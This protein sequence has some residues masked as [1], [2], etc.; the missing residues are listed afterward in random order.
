GDKYYF[1][2]INF[3]GNNAYEDEYLHQILRIKKGDA[4][5]GTLLEKRIADN[6]KPDA[7]DI[8]NLYQN[9][10][11]LFSQINPVETKVY[12][13]TIDFEIRIMEGK[14]AHFD[15]VYVTGNDKTNDHVIYRNLR[16]RPGEHTVKRMWSEPFVNSVS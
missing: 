5:N 7:E 12:N 10:G 11:Y 13:D 15:H 2:E 4:Y 9:N 16:T 6:T 1:G 8:T 3:L 14:I